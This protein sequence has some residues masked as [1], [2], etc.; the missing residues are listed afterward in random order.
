MDFYCHKFFTNCRVIPLFQEQ[1]T[2][3]PCKQTNMNI[4]LSVL[5][6]SIV[7]AFV[8]ITSGCSSVVV[9]EKGKDDPKLVVQV[10]VIEPSKKEALQ[11]FI[12]GTGFEARGDYFLAVNA[13]LKAFEYDPSPGISYAIGRCYYFLGK[14][15]QA[16]PYAR[17]AALNDGETME[18]FY[19]LSDIHLSARQPDSAAAV[20]EKLVEKY[21]N[22]YNC[23]YRLAGI[24]EKSKPLSAIEIYKRI[25]DE[26]PED[27]NAYIRLAD[28]YDKTGNKEASTQILEEFLEYNPS[29]LELREILINNYVEQ[30]K[31][32]LALQH[33]DGILM[34]FPDRIPTLEAK[35]RIFVEKEDYLGASEPYIRLVKNPGVN[36]EFKLNLGGLY[37]EQ[38][39]KDSQYIRIVDTLFTAI[40]KDTVFWFTH[41]YTGANAVLKK[42]S[43]TAQER[44]GKI[45][46]DSYMYLQLWQRI[47]GVLYDGKLYKESSF[48]LKRAWESFSEDFI[49]N[50]LLGLSYALTGDYGA[51]EPFLYKATQL[52]PAEVNTFSAYAFTLSRLKMNDL[53]IE[54]YKRALQIEPENV[55]LINSLAIVYDGMGAQTVSDSL[56]T[57]SLELDPK[58]ALACNNFAYSLAKRNVRLDDALRYAEMAL[59]IDPNSPSYLDTYGWVQFKL[60][61]YD[62]AKVYI[63]KAL[64]MDGDNHELLDHIGD[65]L[66]M[67]GDKEN[68]KKYWKRALELNKENETIKRKIERG[69]I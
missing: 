37:F 65:V 19:L 44:F 49:I 53:A 38:A 54:N 30:K 66:F 41:F 23:L 55:E 9:E 6:F 25:L 46:G 8:L 56:Y 12:T 13:Y 68:A 39:V 60:G 50:F 51:S 52:N 18:Y 20:I 5:K 29:S 61:N 3:S 47:G 45:Q 1:S 62:T 17:A 31:Y 35:A 59:A 16:L 32:D 4:Y 7:C 33:L 58:N 42:D 15:S 34:L 48:V 22:D 21:P 43:L 57:K 11:N 24:Y 63:E 67:L 64:T 69:E 26:E 28:L 10:P 36:L 14:L 40:E 2:E 27:W